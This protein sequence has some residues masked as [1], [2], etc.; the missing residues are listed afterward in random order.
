MKVLYWN[1]YVG[2]HVDDV[3]REVRGMIKSYHPEV[4]GLGEC[5]RVS[6]HL[7]K[8][9]G[10]TAYT[11]PEKTPG[12]SDTAV[13]VRN[14]VPLKRWR[15]L[16]MY[17]W[18]KGPKHGKVQGPKRYWSGRFKV[19]GRVLRLSIGHWP[20]NDA[21][22]ETEDRIAQWFQRTIPL[23]KSA[24]LGDL[25]MGP[26]ETGRYVKRFRGKH[27]GHGVDRC[28][29]KNMKVTFRPLGKHGSDHEAVL[30]TLS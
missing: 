30:F 11:L 3:L 9:P 13:L 10:Y 14:D 27:T 6:P 26:D 7:D 17:R 12:S 15:W 16:E 23:R 28:L 8:I 19:N 22:N 1:V 25:N 5:M 24:H 4:V 21:V 20:F 29:Y 18:W 2:H